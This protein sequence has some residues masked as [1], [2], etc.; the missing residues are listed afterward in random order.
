[1]IPLCSH[2]MKPQDALEVRFVAG[3]TLAWCA[4]CWDAYDRDLLLYGE[5]VA[6]VEAR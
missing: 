1:M 2:C 6:V 3:L 4:D 5:H